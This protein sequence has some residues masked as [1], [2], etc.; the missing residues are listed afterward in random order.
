MLTLWLLVLM[1]KVPVGL[2]PADTMRVTAHIYLSF[3]DGPITASRVV[4][5]LANEDSIPINMFVI[6]KYVHK[7]DTMRALFDSLR[8]NPLIEIGNHSYSHANRHYRSFYLHTP[9]AVQDIQLNADTLG[10]DND[11][12][13]LPGRNMWRLGGWARSDLES[14]KA[15]ADTLAL[16]GYRVFGWDIE[17]QTDS[18]GKMNR[19][20]TEMMKAV[21]Q[22]LANRQAFTQGHVVVLLHD[23][24]MESPWN[25]AQFRAFVDMIKAHGGY[26]LEHLSHYPAG[27]RPLPITLPLYKTTD[28]NQRRP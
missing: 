15:V 23:A 17:W 2:T 4:Q 20:A 13:R 8:T 1:I 25:D 9:S 18:C 10:L 14:G 11:L 27:Q 26:R 12:V 16:L 19:T 5:Q 28:H 21:E 3:D 6:G 7:N 24:M 22:L